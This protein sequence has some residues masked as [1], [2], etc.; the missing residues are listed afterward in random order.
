MLY[1]NAK[2][3]NVLRLSSNFMWV[4]VLVY[5]SCIL[6]IICFAKSKMELCFAKQLTYLSLH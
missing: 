1:K 5:S 4:D 3:V 6:K 2:N